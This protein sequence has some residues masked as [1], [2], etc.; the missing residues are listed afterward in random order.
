MTPTILY[1]PIPE[2]YKGPCTIAITSLDGVITLIA[3]GN[4]HEL[5]RRIG[6]NL[7]TFKG[8]YRILRRFY[9]ISI[10]AMRILE[11]VVEKIRRGE[12]QDL[13]QLLQK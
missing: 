3:A 9:G 12:Q 2:K 7:V 10:E 11:D 1:D 13:D 6:Q 5:E 4:A 8:D